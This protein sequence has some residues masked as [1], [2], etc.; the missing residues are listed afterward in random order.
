MNAIAQPVT[1]QAA[2][3]ERRPSGWRHLKTLLPYVAHYK[4]M[5]ALGML[6]LA[7][8]GIVGALPQLIQGIIVDSLNG[9]PRPLATL[10]GT[11]R[12]VLH[13]ILSFYAPRNHRA[14]ALYCITIVVAM[15]VKGFFSFW[16]RWIL[17]GVSREIEYDLRND[18]LARLVKLE[19]EFYVRN[20]TGDLMSRATNDLNAVRMV[21][22]PGI[23][24]TANTIATSVLALYFMIKLSPGLT[25]WVLLP[26]PFVVV[27]VYYFG[28]I[29]H[30][31]SER[32]QAALGSLSTRAQENLTGIRVVRAYAQENQEIGSFDR[33]NRD[34]VEHNIQLITSWSLFFPGL[35][36]LIGLTIVIL[37]GK[38]GIA[39][40]DH[41]VSVGTLWAF[42]TFLL[43]LTFPIIALGWVTNIFQR[44]AASMGRLLYIL[45]A[46]PNI[47]DATAAP[48]HAG[49]NGQPHDGPA[50]AAT[51]VAK[52]GI[53]G[54]IEFR[55]L[56]F[57]YPTAPNEPVL[58]DISL[59][60]PAGSA[61][62][63]VGPTGS[64]KSTLAALIARL[65]EAPA[66]T[67]LID[68][69][70]I[71]DYP[72]GELRR[73]IGYVPQ[74]TF[75]FSETLRE[76]IA[77]GAP[78]AREE[79]IRECAAIACVSG[80]I[81]GFAQGYETMVGERGITLSGGQKQRTSLARA[82]MRQ[83]KILILDDSLSSVDTD[84]EERILRGLR[85]V[86]RERTTILVSHRV[87]TV[88]DADQIVVLHAGKIIERGTH[89]EL[90]AFSGEYAD[91]YQKQLLEEELE[92]E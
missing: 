35:T 6:A 46:E 52:D 61:L 19:P 75:L 25:L 58:R 23:M 62:A 7:L 59:R 72:L 41:R 60:V 21:L 65:W 39:V 50:V 37:L 3:P 1:R 81:E 11:S 5:T 22:G 66:G 9:L 33:V 80:E 48:V 4:G 87:S 44:G 88:K 53:R 63:I 30:R 45:R 28:R 38:G 57:A 36:T 29:I 91:L 79:E 69:R 86:M 70:S 8:M 84:T 42:Y 90:L 64:G 56:T 55:H 85:Q 27:S 73:A 20:R 74:D 43:Q 67:L 18:L 16:S 40:I 10:A 13:P 2:R 14:L 32:I 17:I 76:N 26:V 12:A 54:D 15:L 78:E 49:G 51:S 89:E 92:R 82:I 68:G 24:Y 71:R 34:Y 31:L 83:P 47:D 77:F